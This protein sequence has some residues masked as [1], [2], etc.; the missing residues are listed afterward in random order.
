MKKKRANKMCDAL[1]A[2]IHNRNLYR[3]GRRFINARPFRKDGA[4]IVGGAYYEV[5]V[6]DLQSNTPMPFHNDGSFVDGNNVPV[7]LL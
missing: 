3:N 6:D 4:V 7:V 5:W 2:I 1:N